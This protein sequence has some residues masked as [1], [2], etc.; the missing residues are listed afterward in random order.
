MDNLEIDRNIDKKL[1]SPKSENFY[2]K[3]L[4]K[5]KS[6]QFEERSWERESY[7]TNFRDKIELYEKLKRTEDS[8]NSGE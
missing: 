2:I 5:W 6:L 3:Y 8:L 7:L 4:V 1:P